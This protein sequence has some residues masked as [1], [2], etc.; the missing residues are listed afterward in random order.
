MGNN[1]DV[2]APPGS[3]P[4]P[5][6]SSKSRGWK[7]LA[8]WTCILILINLYLAF[9]VTASQAE[10]KSLGTLIGFVIG[11]AIG[12]PFI[13]L[14]LSQIWQKHRNGRSRVKAVLYPSYLV[15][16]TQGMAFFNLVSKIAGKST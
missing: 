1:D 16:I 7:L 15:L 12:L 6:E 2:Y 9:I 13:V 3:D 4:Q 8:V 11:N 10:F 5:G 14:L